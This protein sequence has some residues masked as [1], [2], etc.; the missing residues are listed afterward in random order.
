MSLTLLY[1]VCELS[2]LPGYRVFC[3]HARGLPGPFWMPVEFLQKILTLSPDALWCWDCCSMLDTLALLV[4][5]LSEHFP[6]FP[7]KLGSGRISYKSF[8]SMLQLYLAGGSQ[9]NMVVF[10]RNLINMSWIWTPVIVYSFL[11]VFIGY[12]LTCFCCMITLWSIIFSVKPK[13]HSSKLLLRAPSPKPHLD[14]SPCASV[15][16]KLDLAVR[17]FCVAVFYIGLWPSLEASKAGWPL[18]NHEM[19]YLINPSLQRL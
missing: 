19:P 9:I 10:Q 3:K 7:V 16:C 5:W 12:S 17:T 1:S 14:S 8:K 11:R 13:I 2:Y 15:V 18:K 6:I 4:L